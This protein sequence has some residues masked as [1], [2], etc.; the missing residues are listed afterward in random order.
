[1]VLA[2]LSSAQS[3][4][5]LPGEVQLPQLRVGQ[6]EGVDRLEERLKGPVAVSVLPLQLQQVPVQR[7]LIVPLVPLAELAAHHQ[8]LL[9]RVGE[10]IGIESP[11]AGK[12][13]LVCSGHLVDE[14]ALHVHYLIVGQGE[15]KILREGIHQREGNIVV[16]ELAEVGVH[17]NVVE[18]VVHPP[19]FHFRLK[20]RPPSS[21]PLS[22]GWETRGQAVDSSAIIITSLWAL[23][24][25]VLSCWRNSTASRFSCPPNTLGTHWPSCRP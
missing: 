1:M 22:T 17:F 24:M 20:P 4:Q 7:V 19:M 18:N 23:K 3:T 14:G 2:W 6:V 13:L 9:A 12:F 21:P 16:V 25:W 15:H 8:Q 5:S 11:H 10:H